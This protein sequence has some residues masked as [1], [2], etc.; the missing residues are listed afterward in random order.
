MRI[1]IN[2][3]ITVSILSGGLP[4]QMMKTGVRTKAAISGSEPARHINCPFIAS[5]Y[6]ERAPY[7][8]SARIVNKSCHG[9]PSCIFDAAMHLL[10]HHGIPTAAAGEPDDDN[11]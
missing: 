11:G 5:S 2:S 3:G 10:A 6:Q 9:I 4:A 7:T 1:S 8:E